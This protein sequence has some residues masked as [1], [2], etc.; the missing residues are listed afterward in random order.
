V[1]LARNVIGGIRMLKVFAWE[2]PM[3][4]RIADVRAQEVDRIAQASVLRAMNE[5]LFGSMTTVVAAATFLVASLAL[6][7]ELSTRRV[8]VVLGLFNLLQLVAAKFI[9]LAIEFASETTTALRRLTEVL[10]LPEK[11]PLL[12][13][14]QGG[15]GARR[16]QDHAASGRGGSGKQL[17]HEGEE[18]KL[19]LAELRGFFARWGEEDDGDEGRTGEAARNSASP[20]P[21]PGPGGE[22]DGRRSPSGHAWTL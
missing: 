18:E 19:P 12:M 20:G 11:V 3:A 2:G 17:E 5:A 22:S 16:E 4:K 8:L 13:L 10:V 7:E 15:S 6:G 21:G 9:P 14:E 1:Q